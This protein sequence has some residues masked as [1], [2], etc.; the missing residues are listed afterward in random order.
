MWKHDFI[1]CLNATSAGDLQIQKAMMI[2]HAHL[3]R[4]INKYRACNQSALS[5]L[6]TDSVWLSATTA[7]ND[8]FDSAIALSFAHLSESTFSMD[9]APYADKL[10]ASLTDAQIAEVKAS[11]KPLEV[12]ASI[13]LEKDGRIP[14]DE[15]EGAKKLLQ[16]AVEHVSRPILEVARKFIQARTVLCSF[17]EVHDSIIMWGHYSDGHQGI[18]IQ[19]DINGLHPDK[20][21]FLWPVIYSNELFDATKYIVAAIRNISAFNNLFPTVAALYKSPEWAYEKEWR[22]LFPGG[23]MRP[24]NY[25]MPRPSRV[26]LGAKM[27]DSDKTNV[28][29]IC[30]GKD[31]ECHQMGLAARTFKFEHQRI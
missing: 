7:Y 28:L 19:Y 4:F 30:R 13:V 21:Q 29:G 11:P 25:D 23:V 17:S 3:P 2:K 18:C 6:E 8:P 12:L 26:F 24:G 9:T 14:A 10:K 27:S 5:N 20:R 1:A 15:I 31:I 22:F 16:N